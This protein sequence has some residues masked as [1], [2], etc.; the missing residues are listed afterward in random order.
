[1][2]R[3]PG[4]RFATDCTI[5]VDVRPVAARTGESVAVALL[6]AGRALIARSSK[7]HRPRGA[8]CLAGSCH[9][10]LARVDGV[11]NRRTCRVPCR[12]GLSVESQNALPSAPHDVLGAVD[13]LYADGLDHHH[14]MTWNSLANRAAVAFSRRLAGLGTL[15]DRAPPPCAPPPLQP[16]HPL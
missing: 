6:A 12:P 14:L 7:Y 16:F 15:P 13:H 11:P 3:L 1:M 8:F 10:C 4:P 2:P 5:D 9:A